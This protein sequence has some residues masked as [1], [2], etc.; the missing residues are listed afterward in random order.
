MAWAAE[1][2]IRHTTIADTIVFNFIGS[3]PY[4]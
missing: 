4:G 1:L 2:T 3:A